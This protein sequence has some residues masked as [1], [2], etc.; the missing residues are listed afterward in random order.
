MSQFDSTSTAA[1]VAEG[2]DLA[3]LRTVITGGSSGLGAETARVLA[4]ARADVTLAVRDMQAGRAA[5]ATMTG[6]VTVAPLDLADEAS[7]RAFA[8]A[9]DGPLHLLINNAGIMAVTDLERTKAGR[10]LQF[11]TNHIGHF[12]LATG[13]H[14]ALARGAQETDGA[15]IVSLSSRGHLVAAVDLDDPDFER[16][17]YHP[18]AAYGQ[19][20][21]ANVLF[22]VEAARRWADDGITANALMPG[23]IADT[24]LARHMDMEQ[25]SAFIASG[26]LALP[27]QK[28]VEQGAA[29]SVLLAASPTVQ[30]ITGR[31]FEDCAEAE[32]V[33]ERAGSAAGVAPYALDP[34]NAARLWSVSEAF[35]R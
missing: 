3:G 20:K 30:G 8:E 35:L 14:D 23:N 21:T 27:P 5:A 13:L 31:Y 2:L 19:S 7:A 32:T 34:D 17:P 10:E 12:V 24:S 25:V 1:E 33:Y 15:R 26:E 11:G 18:F 6:T 16:R 9:W 22:A 4:A 29:T 28:T